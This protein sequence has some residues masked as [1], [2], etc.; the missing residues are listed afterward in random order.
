ME[1]FLKKALP[2]MAKAG[3]YIGVYFTFLCVAAFPLMHV[4]LMLGKDVAVTAFVAGGIAFVILC[5]AFF[6]LVRTSVM[7]G[8]TLRETYLA[9]PADTARGKCAFFLSRPSFWVETACASLLFYIFSTRLLWA[10]SVARGYEHFSLPP[11]WI[12]FAAVFPVFFALNVLA[13]LSAAKWW[14]SMP[15]FDYSYKAYIKQLIT[16]AIVYFLGGAF[17]PMG[18]Q[19]LVGLFFGGGYV[20][21]LILQSIWPIVLLFLFILSFRAYRKRRALLK[22]LERICRE[23]EY[24][25]SGVRHPYLSVIRFSAGESFSVETPDGRYSVKLIGGVRRMVPLILQT[26]GTGCFVHR[27]CIR[28]FELLRY[29]SV[30]TFGYDST[31]KRIL[32]INPIPKKVFLRDMGKTVLIDNG[33]RVGDFRIYTGSAFVNALEREC[34]DR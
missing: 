25:L 4:V 6:S 22:D 31:D 14:R 20:A 21:L 15:S 18:I 13:R 26:D 12:L 28:K 29:E 30:F 24:T 33:D 9:R 10:S 3:S 7:F 17:L 8:K 11:K 27:L 5:M 2:V 23:K 1:N 34:L 19:V 32:V 16:T